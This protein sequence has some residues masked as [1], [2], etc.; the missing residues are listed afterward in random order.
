MK[1][2]AI[3]SLCPN[4]MSWWHIAGAKSSYG[5]VFNDPLAATS[6]VPVL[7]PV[8]H[9][10]TFCV[11][12]Q[13]PTHIQLW[14]INKTSYVCFL[15]SNTVFIV[16]PISVSC[17][18][19]NTPG[20]KK[21]GVFFHPLLFDFRKSIFFWKAPR[22]R[23]FVF[24]VRATCTGRW[25]VWSVIILTPGKHSSHSGLPKRIPHRERSNSCYHGNLPTKEGRNELDIY[26]CM[27]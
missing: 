10:I 17:I 11:Q 9:G 6:R 1:F 25:W 21:V 3:W 4:T 7:R 12:R 5:S 16:L 8:W 19:D 2:M 26:E 23:L 22:H 13:L 14:D 24:L 18:A 27:H 20:E 15:L